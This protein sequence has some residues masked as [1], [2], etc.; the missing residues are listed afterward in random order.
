[1]FSFIL[2]LLI[3]SLSIDSLLKVIVNG[4]AEEAS[5]FTARQ[6]NQDQ[7]EQE[8][9]E[10]KTTSESSDVKVGVVSFRGV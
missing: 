2:Y 3:L 7:Q 1:M 6:Q 9:S 5:A 8:D 10:E 4:S